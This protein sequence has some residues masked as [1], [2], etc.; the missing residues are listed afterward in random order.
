MDFPSLAEGQVWFLSVKVTRSIVSLHFFLLL[1]NDILL[2]M[3]IFNLLLFLISLA[4]NNKICG[5]SY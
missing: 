1:I 5:K 3:E 2:K 4:A